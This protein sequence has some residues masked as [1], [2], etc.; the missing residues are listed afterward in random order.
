M[1][2]ADTSAGAQGELRVLAGLAD[3][4]LT[5]FIGIVVFHLLIGPTRGPSSK[6][7]LR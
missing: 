2:W 4:N 5:C 6:L 7:S 3:I 1:A